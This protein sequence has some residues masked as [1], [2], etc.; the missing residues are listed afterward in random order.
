MADM[1]QSSTPDKIEVTQRAG[2]LRQ[3]E[4]GWNGY[5]ALPPDDDCIDRAEQW[6]GTLQRMGCP[7]VNITPGSD[8]SVMVSTAGEDE[9][10]F[11]FYPNRVNE[12]E[13][14]SVFHGLERAPITF[15]AQGDGSPKGGNAAGGAVEDDSPV[16]Q[17]ADAPKGAHH[18]H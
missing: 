18:D 9:A 15:P 11:D 5:G 2:E 13:L 10:C 4:K 12:E 7:A 8:G 3:L 17:Q 6:A 1:T 14:W 16:G